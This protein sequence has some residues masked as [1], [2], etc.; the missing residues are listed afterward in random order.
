MKKDRAKTITGQALAAACGGAIA[1]S[2]EHAIAQDPDADVRG[3][4]LI[5]VTGSH[6]K[7]TEAESALP[8]QIIT[9]D[10]MINGGIQTAQELLERVSANQSFGGS[11]PALGIGSSL[12]GFTAASLRGLGSERT[13]VLLNGRRLAPYALSGGDSVDL[14]GIPLSAIERVEILKDGASAIYGTDA[15]GGVINFILRKDFK[16]FEIYGDYYVTEHPGGNSQRANAT[17]GVGSLDSDRYNAFLSIDYFKQ[18]SLAARQREFSRTAHIP[19]L[20]LDASST[21]TIPANILQWDGFSQPWGFSGIHNPTIPFPGGATPASC[22]P[23]YSFPS[24]DPNFPVCVFDATSV[25]DTIPDSEKFNAIGRL[26]WQATSSDQVFVEGTYYHGRFVQR[27]APTPVLSPFEFGND[28]SLLPSS[29]FYPAAYVASLPGGDPTQ[30]LEILYRLLE[31]GP[32]VEQ[33]VSDQWTAVVGMQGT[34]NGWDYQGSA[35]WV[36]N[37]QKSAYVSGYVDATRLAPLLHSGTVNEFGFNTPD[38]VQQLRDTQVFGP[39]HDNRAS[40]YGA[41]F[42]MSRDVLALPAGPLAVAAGLEGRRESLEQLRSELTASGNIVSTGGAVPSIPTA[43]RTVWAAFAEANIPVLKSLEADIAVRFDH[44][45]DFGSTTNPK[46]SLR[47][48][49]A[50]N[51]LL[52]GAYGTGFRAPTLSELFQPLGTGF[53]GGS[54]PIRCPV[55]DSEFDCNAFFHAVDGGNPALQPERS[56]QFTAGIVLEP[57]AGLSASLDYYHVEIRN[58]VQ[59]VDENTIFDN[60]A[61]LGPSLVVRGPPDEEFPDLP[62]PIELVKRIPWNL[63]TLKT[64]GIDVDVRYRAPTTA[65]G[66]FTFSIDGTY[67]LDYSLN[68]VNSAPFPGGAGERGPFTAAISRWRHYAAMDWTRGPWA[69]TLANTFQLGYDEPCILDDKG[70]SLDAS[71]CLT[72]RVGSYSVW[73]LQL[74][75]SGFTNT[76]LTLG[77]RNLLDRAPPLTNQAGAF[78]IGF[79]P[80]YAD[81]RGRMFYGAIRYAFK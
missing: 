52:R 18:D 29:P 50:R 75:Y 57:A 23:P 3:T 67:V 2:V 78:Q 28:Y 71:G 27:I 26:T 61:A 22:L 16:G 73:D 54:D 76:V 40:N 79:D 20:G 77:V 11:N 56:K 66:Q 65:F 37:Q 74:R 36:R 25:I 33:T 44:Y 64:S 62:G 59:F 45:S 32:R 70:A 39:A 68:G 15:I 5:D 12:T 72:R 41:D 43:Y 10:E 48:Q 31:L 53:A 55:T 46:L 80:T 49:P 35:N 24:V 19:S 42:R 81:P 58:L 6:V 63:G 4:I 69:A 13:L 9:R 21:G 60:Y 34:R 51:V 17:L 47:W 8:L 1:L 30:R 7:R 38:I 14:S